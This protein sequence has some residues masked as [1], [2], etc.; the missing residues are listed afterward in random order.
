M[1]EW[2]VYFVAD[3]AAGKLTW[4]TRPRSHFIREQPWKM[5]NRRF[6]GKIAGSSDGIGYQRVEIAN[7]FYRVHRILF[8]M[9]NGPIPSHLCIDHIDRNRGNN[10]LS[11]LRLVTPLENARNRSRR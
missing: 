11:N 9:A 1:N 10:T 2:E 7:K 6:A 8:E 5:W 4:R 3:F